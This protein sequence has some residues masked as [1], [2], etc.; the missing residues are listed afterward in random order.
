MILSDFF[1]S[2]WLVGVLLVVSL[3]IFLF[4]Y[5]AARIFYRPKGIGTRGRGLT[6]SG[7]QAGL[8]LGFVGMVAGFLTGSSREPAVSAIVPAILTFIG[9][10]V[11]YMIGKSNL[12][13]IIVGFAVFVFSVDLLVGSVLGSA[14]RNRYDELLTSIEFQKRKADQEFAI[15][16]Y[17]RA[18]GLPLDGGAKPS[19]PVLSPDNR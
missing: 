19:P 18:L 11:V 1:N 13:S 10:V 17:R 15:R 3:L 8:P 4:L 7:F 6:L 14:S 9:L 16:L 5:I 12:R 2:I